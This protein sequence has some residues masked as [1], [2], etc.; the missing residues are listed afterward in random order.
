VGNHGH[1]RRGDDEGLQVTPV[2]APIAAA[3][4]DVPA[5]SSIQIEDLP[6]LVLLPASLASEIRSSFNTAER[7]RGSPS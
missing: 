2:R 1:D 5:L 4:Y 3:L 7:R 6:L